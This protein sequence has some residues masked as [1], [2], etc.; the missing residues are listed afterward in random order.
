MLLGHKSSRMT[1]R[2]SHLA[3]GNLRDTVS[4]VDILKV[5]EGVG[6]KS[7]TIGG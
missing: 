1:Q 7:V 4:E 6:H 2:H 3:S 5:A